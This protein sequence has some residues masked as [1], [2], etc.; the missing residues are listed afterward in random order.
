MFDLS[1]S[2]LKIVSLFSGCGGFDHGFEQAGFKIHFAVDQSRDAVN[3][4]NSNLR[5]VARQVNICKDLRF[6]FKPDIIIAGPPC[7]G[8]STGGGYKAHDERNDLF[9][10]TCAIIARSQPR[11][12]IIENVEAI[13]NS[14]NNEYFRMSLELLSSAGYHCEWSVLSAS[15]FGVAQRRRRA[16]IIARK[17]APFTM[18]RSPK[19]ETIL[20]SSALAAISDADTSHKPT[21]PAQASRHC[22]IA[23]HIKPG[24]KLCNVRSGSKSIPTWRIPEVFGVVNDSERAIL[25]TIRQIRRTERKRNHGDADPVGLDRLF[26]VLPSAN[27]CSIESL[28]KLGYLR[29]IGQDID[30]T[31]TFNG[32]YRRLCLDNLSP[33]VDTRFG[34]IQ[35]FLHPVENRG[36]TVREAA[37]I[38]GFSDEIRFP[39]SEKTAFRLIGNAVPPPMAFQL[40]KFCRE[41]L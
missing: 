19:R 38:Q 28:T 4:Y 32:K 27:I 11:V 13:T 30:L 26:S 31:N 29:V 33:T 1:S 40:A 10:S 20:L 36:M 3:A 37:R 12:A 16:V 8:F 35:L 23:A 14:R 22:R 9:I 24:Q 41:L 5:P 6:E 2:E 15:D 7:Q 25:E 21:Y 18:Y 34:D 17:D 39:H